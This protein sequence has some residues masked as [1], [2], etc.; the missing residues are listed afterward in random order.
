MSGAAPG[1]TIFTPLY[2]TGLWLPV[3]LAPPSSFQCAVA[4]YS[5]GVVTVPMSTTSMPAARAPSTKPALR[6]V[7]D[8]RLSWPTAIVR[9]PLLRISVPYARPTR[10]KTSGLMSEP[11]RPRTS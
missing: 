8:S 3:M 10:R 11:T 7:D 2:S 6:P 9:P 5:M 1:C 4:K